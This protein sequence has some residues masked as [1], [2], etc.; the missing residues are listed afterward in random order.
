MRKL[1]LLSPLAP[2]QRMI[3]VQQVEFSYANTGFRLAVPELMIG[4]GERVALVGPSGSGKSTL[5]NLLGGILLPDRGSIKVAGRQVVEMKERGRRAYRAQ[6]MGLVFQEFELL[7]YLNVRDNILLPYRI[8][9]QLR[10]TSDVVQRA[11]DLAGDLEIQDQLLRFP[12]QL[13]QGERQRVAIGRAL[14]ADPRLLLADEPTGN[15][16]PRNKQR[17]LDLLLRH[18]DQRRLTVV[19]VTHDHGLLERFERVIQVSEFAMDDPG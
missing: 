13:S 8:S 3:E 4:D 17:V 2:N 6:T 12:G 9:G 16:D 15:L 19:M 14:I 18:A 11:E 5:L 7:E 1:F 10:L